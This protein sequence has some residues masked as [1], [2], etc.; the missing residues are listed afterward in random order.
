MIENSIFFKYCELKYA[1]ADEKLDNLLHFLI[2]T[3]YFLDEII[4]RANVEFYWISRF[5][6]GEELKADEIDHELLKLN[7][8]VRNYSQVCIWKYLPPLKSTYTYYFIDGD[9]DSIYSKLFRIY[10]M[11]AFL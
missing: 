7:C 1:Y 9:S 2:Q 11:R 10:K 5:I 8:P 6:D 4:K 3:P